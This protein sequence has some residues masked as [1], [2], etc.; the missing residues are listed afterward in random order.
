VAATA[1]VAPPVVVAVT[2]VDRPL[3]PQEQAAAAY[4]RALAAQRTGQRTSMEMELRQALAQDPSHLLARETLAASLYRSGRLEEAKPVLRGGITEAS[5]PVSLRKTL[6]RILVDQGA[7]EEA[8]LALLHGGAPPVAQDTEFHQLLAAIYQRTGQYAAAAQTY[9]QLLT[10][11]RDT[12]V[13]WLGLGL[14]LESSRALA[15]A[16]QAYRSALQDPALQTGLGDFARGR[17]V[18]LTAEGV[19]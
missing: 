11:Q 6:A 17:V 10:V 3:S 7:P 8:A 12:G 14:A 5:A 18:A 15:E 13:W 9:R 19:N 4:Q 16:K 2:K 1:T